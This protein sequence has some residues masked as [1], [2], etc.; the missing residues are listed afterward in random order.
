MFPLALIAICPL[1]GSLPDHPSGSPSEPPARAAAPPASPSLRLTKGMV[2]VDLAG[3]NMVR[4]DVL[5]LEG[6]FVQELPISQRV[7][8]LARYV[9]PQ[10]AKEGRLVVRVR[11]RE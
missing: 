9:L 3:R 5:D 10:A 11:D 6:R 2:E 8:D 7:G 4:V 1:F